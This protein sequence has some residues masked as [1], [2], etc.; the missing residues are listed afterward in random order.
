M[1]RTRRRSASTSPI[2]KWISFSGSTGLFSYFDKSVGEN[3]ERVE[4]E[5]LSLI[6]LDVRASV[7][8]YNETKK[9]QIS[10]NM[11]A[12]PNDDILTVVGFAN[13]NKYEIATGIYKDIKEAVKKEKGKYTQNII[14]LAD[15]GNGH[16]VVC[17]QV[18]GS[19]LNSWINFTQLHPNDG[20]YDFEI[21]FNKGALSK[22]DGDEFV[23]VTKKE[24]KE[25]DA[26]LAKN[27][28]APRPVWF[29]LMEM[30][31]EDLTEDQIDMAVEEDEK[32]Q[33]YFSSNSTEDKKGKSN[34]DKSSTEQ[35]EEED[36]DEED[37]D[38][39]PF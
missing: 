29:Y 27:P 39:L 12:N 8:G 36:D 1:S 2:K 32:L 17:L 7:T 26:K 24:E 23:P 31:V 38:D 18:N 19:A 15:L 13:K 21:T 3:G 4:L 6:V 10:S 35:E 9:S 28:R 20:Y 33:E 14:G 37:G 25:L 30:S 5:S 16:E 34:G 22:V 11:I